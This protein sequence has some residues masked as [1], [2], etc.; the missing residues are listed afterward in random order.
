MGRGSRN[1]VNS[2]KP[3]DFAG[4]GFAGLSAMELNKR[5]A[6]FFFGGAGLM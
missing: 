1:E 5:N 3:E 6:G 2:Q 4:G